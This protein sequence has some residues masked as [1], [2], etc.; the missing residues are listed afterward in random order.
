MLERHH[1]A[2]RHL[3]VTPA[4]NLAAHGRQAFFSSG[5]QP[6]VVG[7]DLGWNFGAQLCHVRFPVSLFVPDEFE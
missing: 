4:A 1:H 6:V 7:E 2:E 5:H 3:H